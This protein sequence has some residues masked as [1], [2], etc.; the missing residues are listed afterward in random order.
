M[1]NPLE[2]FENKKLNWFHIKAMLIAGAGQI[3][4]GY[5]LTAGSLVLFSI[6]SYFGASLIAVSLMLFASIILGN[7]VGALLFGYLVRH[8]RKK[9]YGID[10][11]LM[12]FG[13]L[14]LLF[15]TTPYE[16]VLLRFI[17]G[18]GI[19]ADYV[20]S[21]LITAEYANVR[22]RGKLLGLAGG[23]MWNFGALLSAL[24]TLTLENILP[25]STLWRVVLALGS[26]PA[27][28]VVVFRRRL[29]ETPHYLAYVKKDLKE[30]REKYGLNVSSIPEVK[31]V[32]NAIIPTLILASLTWYLYDIVAYAGVFFGPNVIAEKLG[33]NGAVFL[34]LILAIFFIPWTILGA[35]L[36]DKI[37]RRATQ[38]IGFIGMG[39]ATMIFATL[40]GKVDVTITL[41][42]F[43][44]S[45][46]F[47]ALG[48]ANVVGYWGVELFP[49]RIRGI[50]QSITVLSGRLGVITTTFLFPVLLQAFG[51]TV[52]MM[53]LGA[54][55]IMAAIVTM[56]LPE[57]KQKSLSQLEL[58][59]I[60]RAPLVKNEE[61]KG[62]KAF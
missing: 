34:I 5:D 36:S 59:E 7:I 1:K 22:D 33:I 13:A 19:G 55:G 18:V 26:I 32:W 27:I 41:V 4:D 29:P 2:E 62:E 51:L 60:S 11:M 23:F 6:Q 3:V 42:L 10:A 31:I 57:P 25:P 46:A 12:I 54:V 58:G 43:G 44:I 38:A 53:V 21:P 28:A 45:S 35:I 15:I 52:T 40:I 16:L 17:L 39:V 49:A 47:N 48:P 37:G 9:F 56:M 24:A 8:G 61:D 30:L 50:T 14:L 20:I